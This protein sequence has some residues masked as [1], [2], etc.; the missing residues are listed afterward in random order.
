MRVRD[1]ERLGWLL[2]GAYHP[3]RHLVVVQQYLQAVAA[4][5]ARLITHIQP[6]PIL[7]ETGGT[8]AGTVG[9]G[10]ASVVPMVPA[11]LVA[12]EGQECVLLRQGPR[13]VDEHVAHAVG[14]REGMEPLQVQHSL[15]FRLFGVVHG[16]WDQGVQ[17][18]AL[19]IDGLPEVKSHNF[20]GI[21]YV[22]KVDEPDLNVVGGIANSIHVSE[23]VMGTAA[24]VDG[25]HVHR[26]PRALCPWLVCKDPQLT[27][28]GAGKEALLVWTDVLQALDLHR[29][30]LAIV[31]NPQP[32]GDGVGRDSAPAGPNEKLA[33]ERIQAESRNLVRDQVIIHTIQY[34]GICIPH[35]HVV[36]RSREEHLAEGVIQ[37]A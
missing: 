24:G 25:T 10:G 4:D 26:D 30:D 11:A 17:P 31:T 14:G 23:H 28:G 22:S 1:L 37:N 16:M 3:M 15:H 21:A 20:P 13:A 33:M 35:P 2:R 7:Q 6:R 18:E 5:T 9:Q 36:F 8:D 12:P 32:I 29:V 19:R 34:P 27:I